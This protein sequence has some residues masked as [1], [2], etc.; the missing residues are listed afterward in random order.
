MKKA[1]VV[2]FIF[3]LPMF[4]IFLPNAIAVI[5]DH[6]EL[7]ASYSADSPV[8]DGYLGSAE[9]SDATGYKV[10][11]TGPTDIS[12]WLY[13]KHNGTHIYVGLVVWQ[14]GTHTTDQFAIFFDEGD[15]GGRGSGT[16]DYALT[17]EQE[18]VKSCKPGPILRDGFYND[19]NWYTFG[20]EVD[21]EADCAYEV[22]HFT[23]VDEI[24]SWEGFGWVDDHWEVEF[25]V[26]FLGNDTGI[27]DG[28]DLNCTVADTVGFK[29]QYFIN[30][31]ANNY[32]YPE[33]GQHLILT[34][35][36]L[37]FS[38][39]P[40]IESCNPSGSKKDVFSLGETVYLNGSGYSSS[41]SYD[42]YIV[43]DVEPWTNGLLIPARVADTLTTVSSD[44][45]GNI[46]PT[47]VW[48]N[49]QTVGR[50]DIIVDVNGNGQY[51]ADID[52]LD[53][54]DV[55]VTAGF[56]VPEFSSI[57][58]IFIV[59]TLLSAILLKKRKLF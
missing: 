47:A 11:L 30:P 31:G 22:D 20:A 12:T 33:G 45:S 50:Y 7:M 44:P 40:I 4:S 37:S 53:D 54:N 48:G 49:P 28:S 2:V 35:A 34:Y 51:D 23:S 46:L 14:I 10:N 55:E 56:I 17:P 9:W 26:P 6:P 3:T 21:F 43:E 16:R 36:N 42:L 57:L 19:T 24:E 32:Y 25:V 52:A 18:D 13:L 38:P 39:P 29:A 41:T 59:A 5:P 8:I 1:L 27:D 15:D 58:L